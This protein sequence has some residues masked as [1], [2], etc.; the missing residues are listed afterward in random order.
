MAKFVPDK[1][2]NIVEKEENARYQ[3]CLLFQQ[4]LQKSISLQSNYLPHNK[5][6]LDI[7]IQGICK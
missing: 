3:H 4:C 2:A 5:K 7:L 6:N 1:I